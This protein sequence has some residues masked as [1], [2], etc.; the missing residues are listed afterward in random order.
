[1]SRIENFESVIEQLK[2]KLREYLESKD[3]NTKKPFSC[4]HPDHN[5]GNPSA[6][7]VPGSDFTKW[8]CF[9]CGAKGDIFDAIHYLEGKPIEGPQFIE[10]VVIPMANES[11]ID[12][13]MKELTEDERYRIDSFTAYK[14]A[15]NYI[16]SHT[17]Q[18]LTDEFARRDWNPEL[19]AS[20]LIGTV[21]SFQEY[22]EYMLSLGFTFSFLDGIDL[23]KEDLFNERNMFFTVGDEHGRPCGFG[24]RN[25]HH[26]PDDKESKKYINTSA[27]CHIY[28][29]SKRLYNIHS[30]KKKTGTLYVMEGYADVE[31]ALQKGVEKV[32]CVGGTAFTDYHVIELS[33]MG[34]TDVT[35]CFDGDA[36]GIERI[37]SILEKFTEHRQFSVHIIII[38]DDLDPDD[39]IR[40]HGREAFLNLRRWSAFEW[41]LNGYDDRIDTVLIRKEIVPIIAAE[42]SPI[43]R[44]RMAKVLSDRIGIS[45]NAILDEVSQTLNEKDDQKAKEQKAILDVLIKDLKTCP[46]DWRLSMTAAMQNLET[47]SIAHTE[48][49]M[50]TSLYLKELDIIMEEEE[51]FEETHSTFYFE[52]MKE[53]SAAVEGDWRSTLNVIGGGANTGKTAIMSNMA[54]GLSQMEEDPPL[55]I[56]HTI[57]DTKKQFTTRLVCQ[58]ASQIM[59]NITLNMIKNPG[60]YPNAKIINK[61]R[62]YAYDQIKQ[63]VA[64][65]Q[66]FVIDG[67]NGQATLAYADN[68][69]GYYHKR[70]GDKKRIVYMLDNFH[71]L[72][73]YVQYEE[74]I[75]FKKLSTAAKDIAKKYE[76]AIWATME[77]SKHGAWA[78]RPTN[79]S[80]AESAAMEYDANLIAHVYND[81]HS[82]RENAEIYFNRQDENGMTYRA[83]RIE[84]IFGKNKLN[85]FKGNLYFDFYTEQSR[86]QPVPAS[87]VQEDI[88]I[89][90]EIKDEER[91]NGNGKY[92]YANAS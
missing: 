46:T 29:K 35:L 64:K 85:A 13:K 59:P 30:A 21:P 77:Y 92:K 66:L 48:E 57:D 44:E 63:L 71:R 69:V 49:Q 17:N 25:L 9:G 61:A 12:I 15:A 6:G 54:L 47:I 34:I 36:R 3:I 26:N 18:D 40:T 31:T 88:K 84:M 62:A 53:L 39:Y 91:R 55:V 4:I 37:D 5:D 33:R 14:K 52:G 72:R 81:L 27:K 67:E 42:H 73:D 75:R 16:A 56:F 41:K 2:P 70:Y 23:M 32:V 68:I 10:E 79:N 28:E 82:Q 76:I 20:H 8:N 83:P 87:I 86:F 11:G 51:N 24:A 89:A 60:R 22:K 74:R 58:F 65:E 7:L 38:P 43:E 90:K 19:A 50:S 45:S 78:G 1:M 80:I